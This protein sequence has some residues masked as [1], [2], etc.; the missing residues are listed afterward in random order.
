MPKQCC[1]DTWN[2]IPDDE[3]VFILMGRDLTAASR[4]LEWIES[5]KAA[6]VNP[7]KIRRAEEHLADFVNFVQEHPERC[8]MPD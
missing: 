6:S 4:V 5:A 7:D 2:K 8:K 1:K 3:P